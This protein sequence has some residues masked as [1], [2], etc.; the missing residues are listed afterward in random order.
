[1][2]LDNYLSMYSKRITLT[3]DIVET[4]NQKQ[5]C[6]CG[7]DGRSF[8][9]KVYYVVIDTICNE[10]LYGILCPPTLGAMARTID[11]FLSAVTKDRIDVRDYIQD[12]DDSHANEHYQINQPELESLRDLFQFCAQHNLYLHANY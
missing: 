10:S 4:L 11:A 1:M 6:L 2:G 9:G 8:R 3:D 5:L 12:Y 7:F